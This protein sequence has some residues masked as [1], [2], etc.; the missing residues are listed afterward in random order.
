MWTTK[1]KHGIVSLKCGHLF[2]KQCITKWLKKNSSCPQCKQ[3]ATKA[4]IRDIY[5][6][7][8]VATD[9][10]ELENVKRELEQCQLELRK[11]RSKY[12]SQEETMRK[13]MFN[14]KLAEADAA[15]MKKEY[16]EIR[17]KHEQLLKQKSR[18]CLDTSDLERSSSIVS[19]RLD[20]AQ[21]I[22]TSDRQE[23]P[24]KQKSLRLTERL[25][26][27]KGFLHSGMA[28]ILNCE[29]QIAKVNSSF[30]APVHDYLSMQEWCIKDM[31]CH[32]N[33]L[34]VCSANKK[35]G[36][37]KLD[38]FNVVQ[39]YNLSCN[40]FSC[41]W[42]LS[43]PDQDDRCL[44]THVVSGMAN[45]CIEIFDLRCDRKYLLKRTEKINPRKIHFVHY[46]DGFLYIGGLGGFF[47]CMFEPC[48]DICTDPVTIESLYV[49]AGEVF[50]PDGYVLEHATVK[51]CKENAFSLLCFK[52][53]TTTHSVYYLYECSN[54]MNM[55]SAWQSTIPCQADIIVK[56]TDEFIVYLPDINGLRAINV[57]KNEETM[58]PF[59]YSLSEHIK[60]IR[61]SDKNL[62]VLTNESLYKF[63]I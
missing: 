39:T 58:I 14:M 42:I 40:A 8:I 9:T 59:E 28:L 18:T 41:C 62:Y 34:V 22:I 61:A 31:Q 16:E 7:T 32:E 20:D 23:E 50:P 43:K 48:D 54:T 46:H 4:H 10:A 45:S 35:L 11:E 6:P 24:F 51:V 21:Q 1:G 60:S 57:A 3:F 37:I 30:S 25:L 52:E 36:L 2:G 15:K 27:C 12:L 17:R 53:K 5:A 19:A 44:R 56:G 29:T 47:K 33:F 38:S 13:V 63:F 26:G 49:S 55:I